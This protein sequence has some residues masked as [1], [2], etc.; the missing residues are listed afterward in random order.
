MSQFQ[1]VI[2]YLALAFA[3]F[4][5]VTIIRFSVFFVDTFAPMLGLESSSSGQIEEIMS[6]DRQNVS[7]LEIDLTA[8]NIE[9]KNGDKFEA[10]TRNDNIICQQQGQKIKI[11][12]KSKNIFK[13]G[14]TEKITITI[15]DDFVLDAVDFD[16]GA[17]KVTIEKIQAKSANLNLGAGDVSIKEIFISKKLEIDSGAGRVNISS[18]TISH[19]DLDVGVGK[20]SICAK[21]LGNNQIES[22]I[23]E[24]DLVLLEVEDGYKYKIEKGIGSIS[25]N[26]KDIGSSSFGQGQNLIDIEGGIGSI[27]ISDRR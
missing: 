25:Y 15:P 5:V 24:L 9:I 16:A 20:T 21:L 27:K 18:G 8:A 19:L 22:G 1:K 4:L 23:G 10:K 11:K 6:L 12:E 17:G 14:G 26:K 3:V 2:K 13:T 7:Y